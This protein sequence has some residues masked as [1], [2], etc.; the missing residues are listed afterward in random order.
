MADEQAQQDTQQANA[1]Q[2]PTQGGVKVDPA[3]LDAVNAYL[4]VSDEQTRKFGPKPTCMAMMYAAARHGAFM[5]L[6][7]VKPINAADERTQFLDYMTTL[8]RRMLNEHLDGMGE[9]HGIDVGDSELAEDYAAAGVQVGRLKKQT[10][11]AEYVA[12]AGAVPP[13]APVN[14]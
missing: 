5:Y 4:A 11:A 2:D 12:S 10:P 6:S 9:E 13:A 7:S 1:E 3:F 14:E 8:H